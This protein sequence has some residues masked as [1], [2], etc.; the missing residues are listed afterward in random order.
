M[1]IDTGNNL[2]TL[3]DLKDFM[4]ATS[5]GD[6][7]R[8]QDLINAASGTFN[9]YTNRKLK[10]REYSTSTGGEDPEYQDGNGLDYLY[11]KQYPINSS[12]T[13]IKI[14][15]NVNRNYSDTADQVTSTDIVIYKDVGKIFVDNKRFSEGENSIR[16][17]YNG[18]FTI[19]SSSSGSTVGSISYELQY[20][21]KEF[22]RFLWNKE[23]HNRTDN[24]RSQSYEGGAVTYEVNMPWSVKRVLELYRKANSG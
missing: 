24:I 12:I 7:V 19:T 17:S 5:T 2:I 11:A 3:S 1:P 15:I 8:Y 20:A 4:G 23:S 10:A 9:K 14:I 21:A 18:G 22:C 16:L 6:D 13:Q